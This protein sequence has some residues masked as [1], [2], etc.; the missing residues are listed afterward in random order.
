[1]EESAR[2]SM[3]PGAVGAV[4]YLE[5]PFGIL[6]EHPRTGGFDAL[7]I[8]QAPDHRGYV[9]QQAYLH[10]FS[11]IRLYYKV[12]RAV[13]IG[14][15]DVPLPECA[16]ASQLHA[17]NEARARWLEDGMDFRVKAETARAVVR[18]R[19]GPRAIV[20]GGRQ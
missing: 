7:T 12:R 14:H 11:V 4:L 1:M 8:D 16:T 6:V 20:H 13:V 10:P 5:E 9:L 18:A 17:V 15:L 2:R 3:R 19:R